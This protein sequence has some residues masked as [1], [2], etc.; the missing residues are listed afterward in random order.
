M[1]HALPFDEGQKSTSSNRVSIFDIYAERS[2][3]RLLPNVINSG[4]NNVLNGYGSSCY[5]EI[6]F[7]A[8][9]VVDAFFIHQNSM[10]CA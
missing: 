5:P 10:L 9:G 8:I 1:E 6:V 7:G 4:L 2:I 3:R